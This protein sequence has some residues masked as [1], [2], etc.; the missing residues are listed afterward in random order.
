VSNFTLKKSS[1]TYTAVKTSVLNLI[2]SDSLGLVLHFIVKEN[3]N[4]KLLKADLV[5][6]LQ[7]KLCDRFKQNISEYFNNLDNDTL[8]INFKNADE[9]KNKI[10][11]YDLDENT[12]E[13]DLILK[14]HCGSIQESFSFND[15][16][17]KDIV[18]T[19]VNIATASE[20][21]TLYKF[22][23][24]VSTLKKESDGFLS[25]IPFSDSQSTQIDELKKDVFRLSYKFDFFMLD[26]RL[27]ISNL[28]V[29]EDNLKV[30]S[31]IIKAAK[32][33]IDTIKTLNYLH[34]PNCL[35]D[36]IEDISFAR[37]LLKVTE[38]S[39]VI[40]QQIPLE[41]VAKFITERSYLKS[42]KINPE[43]NRLILNSKIS[44][45]KFLKI[46]DDDY[47]KSEL[48]ESEYETLVKDQIKEDPS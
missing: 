15:Q 47:L 35:D 31:I 3:N 5:Q 38:N 22:N 21:I 48:T 18:G 29:I 37:K 1:T 26:S 42:I 2:E 30:H 12:E 23:Y 11:L 39:K 46:L 20:I 33:Q 25:L 43:D 28:K 4:L 16:S 17:F 40:N 14:A 24:P 27:F 32:K 45:Q 10:Y 44:K 13:I 7:E 19:V 8:I 6:T 9:R 36:S 34:N 41:D